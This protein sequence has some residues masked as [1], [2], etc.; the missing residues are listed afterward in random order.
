MV[1]V[2]RSRGKTTPTLD[3]AEP[4]ANAR[5][6]IKAAGPSWGGDVDAPVPVEKRSY[7]DDLRGLASHSHLARRDRVSAK[8]A[9]R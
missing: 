5:D 8:R 7:E 9:G 3:H 1:E 4:N 6:G 2:R